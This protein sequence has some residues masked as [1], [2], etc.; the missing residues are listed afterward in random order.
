MRNLVIS[1]PI[2][3]HQET[4]ETL[5][6]IGV[7]MKVA[8][9]QIFVDCVNGCLPEALIEIDAGF[10][11]EVTPD[12]PDSWGQ[13]EF[14]LQD[15]IQEIKSR[16]PQPDLLIVSGSAARKLSEISLGYAP[17]GFVNPLMLPKDSGIEIPQ[18]E[19]MG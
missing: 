17:E 15:H 12:Q 3:E 18:L 2:G 1:V 4:I 13:P 5:Y 7:K 14:D 9:N 11:V 10:G 16:P 6:K 19:V 8:A